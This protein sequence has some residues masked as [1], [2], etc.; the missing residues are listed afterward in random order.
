MKNRAVLIVAGVIVLGGA[1]ARFTIARRQPSQ[2]LTHAAPSARLASAPNP[3][4]AVSP[5]SNP[6]TAA[7]EPAELPPIAPPQ[8]QPAET[9]RTPTIGR[10]TKAV[11]TNSFV[12]Y[13]GYPLEDPMA[14]LALHFVGEDP[15]AETYWMEAI[16]DPR[17][18][19]EERKDLIED[20]NE[21]GLSDPRHPG[22]Q[23]WPLIL[24]RL[25]LIEEVAPQAMDRV[26]WDA[27]ME[28]YRDLVNLAD[29]QTPQ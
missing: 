27:F 13:N 8:S 25:Q 29:G 5:P 2:T 7:A 17:L 14:R 9:A 21:D 18:P 19:A 26:N 23:D 28:A 12:T 11:E 16:N 22:P 1:V 24:S 15:A 6:R 20:L 3:P 4:P 10:Q